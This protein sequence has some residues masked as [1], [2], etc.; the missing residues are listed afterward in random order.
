VRIFSSFAPCSSF[1]CLPPGKRWRRR[2][3][4]D[5]GSVVIDEIAGMAAGRPPAIPGA[6]A[7]SSFSS[8]CSVV[9]D[10][11]KFGPRRGSTPAGGAVYVVADDLV[12]GCTQDSRTG[13]SYG[14]TG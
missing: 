1:P 4:P 9:F 3:I 2:G 8:C 6:R 5:P 12:A 7:P 13:G 14:L 11:F 10:I